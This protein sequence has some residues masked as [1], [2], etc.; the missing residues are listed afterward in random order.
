MFVV[1]LLSCRNGVGRVEMAP[2]LDNQ[3]LKTLSVF[4]VVQSALSG[5][6]VRH[7]WNM[8]LFFILYCN[9]LCKF[10][11]QLHEITYNR[12]KSSQKST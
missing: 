10:Y 9:I 2:L 4:V 1:N 7:S 6:L 5:Q 3:H 12:N 8:A 11:L